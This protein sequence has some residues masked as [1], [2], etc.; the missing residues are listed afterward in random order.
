MLAYGVVTGVSDSIVVRVD[1]LDFGVNGGVD[2][3]LVFILLFLLFPNILLFWYISLAGCYWNSFN[4][5]LKP[6]SYSSRLIHRMNTK[7]MDTNE[8]KVSGMLLF[9]QNSNASFYLEIKRQRQKQTEMG[10]AHRRLREQ[11]F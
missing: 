3:F 9:R 11:L 2:L 10:P 5:R 7:F 4:S 8:Y 1:E 6:P